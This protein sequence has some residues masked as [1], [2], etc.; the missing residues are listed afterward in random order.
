MPSL[1]HRDTLH[2]WQLIEAQ[3]EYQRRFL[4]ALDRDG[5]LSFPQRRAC[6]DF[7]IDHIARGALRVGDDLVENIGTL[8]FIL[9]ALDIA[10]VR[11]ADGVFHRQ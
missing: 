1:G 2:Y 10:D 8:A 6:Q 4:E 7:A 3:M 9:V 11:R 5:R